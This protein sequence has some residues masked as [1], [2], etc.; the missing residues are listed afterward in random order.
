MRYVAA[1]SFSPLVAFQHTYGSKYY[2]FCVVHTAAAT[3]P[4]LIVRKQNKNAN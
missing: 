4:L 2:A 1:V 3:V